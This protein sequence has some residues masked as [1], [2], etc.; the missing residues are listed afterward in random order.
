MHPAGARLSRLHTDAP[1]SLAPTCSADKPGHS[2]AN[3]ILNLLVTLGT[4]AVVRGLPEPGMQFR[5]SI[6][7]VVASL[8]MCFG[9]SASA[10][11]TED[12]TRLNAA[13]QRYAQREL[14]RGTTV[15]AGGLDARLQLPRCATQP[16]GMR[17]IGNP[18][19]GAATVE[20]R[21]LAS[22]GWKL[23]VPV[24]TQQRSYVVVAKAPIA[25]GTVI[26]PEQL[27]R[28][29]QAVRGATR[30]F[31]KHGV[32]LDSRIK[33]NMIEVIRRC[34]VEKLLRSLKVKTFSWPGIQQPRNVVQADLAHA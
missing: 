25:A 32:S 10:A 34:L 30:G 11:A 6:L 22:P 12:I 33:R 24:R 17:M 29:E 31:R 9:A 18:A 1:S 2:C 26:A 14:P 21:C 8:A 3:S 13:A 27:E 19:S 20:V 5:A 4:N 16:Q 15:T 28:V 7:V 23:F